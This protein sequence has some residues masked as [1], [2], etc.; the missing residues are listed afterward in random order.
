M[1][2]EPEP[3]RI[4]MGESGDLTFVPAVLIRRLYT[5]PDC[6]DQYITANALGKHYEEEHGA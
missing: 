1:S 3:E 6:G 4:D 2:E 5:C